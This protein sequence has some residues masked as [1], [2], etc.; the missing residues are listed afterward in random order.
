MTEFFASLYEF[1]GLL[2]FYSKDF[3]DH[4]CGWA[5]VSIDIGGGTTDVVIFQG[6]A[7]RYLTS[8]EFAANA[9]FGDAYGRR[10]GENHGLVR[11]YLPQYQTL[12]TENRLEELNQVVRSII[13]TNKSDDINSFLFSIERHPRV[14]NRDLF[15]YNKKIITR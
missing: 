6:N 15:S 2:P 7:P 4:L 10:L 12:L 9:I 14:N 3:A 8:F 11:K 5:A 1:F 13:R